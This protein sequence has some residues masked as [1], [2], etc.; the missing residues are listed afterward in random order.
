MP[1]LLNE[2]EDIDFHVKV[3]FLGFVLLLP[4]IS[5][6]DWYSTEHDF[7]PSSPVSRSKTRFGYVSDRDLVV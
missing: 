7:S 6:L 3:G 4:D 2:V 5:R 1:T